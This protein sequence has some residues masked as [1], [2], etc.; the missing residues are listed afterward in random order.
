MKKLTKDELMNIEGGALKFGIL[1][2]IGAA[3]TFIVGVIDGFVRPL[4]CN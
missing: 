2:G 1:V 4:K 3:V